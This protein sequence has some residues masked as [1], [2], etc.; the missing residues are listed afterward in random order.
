MIGWRR[1]EKKDEENLPEKGYGEKEK[2]FLEKVNTW[3]RECQSKSL[4]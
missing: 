2:K 1:T 4:L 3:P